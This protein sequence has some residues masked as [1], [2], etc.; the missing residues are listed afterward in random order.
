MSCGSRFFSFSYPIINDQLPYHRCETIKVFT[1]SHTGSIPS[2][3]Y[4]AF[5][6]A[7]SSLKTRPPKMFYRIGHQILVGIDID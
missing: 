2:V 7:F 1:G 3:L 6:L 4:S 5:P